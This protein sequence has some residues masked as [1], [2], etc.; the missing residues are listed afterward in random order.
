MK[1]NT[2]RAAALAGLM[3]LGA[4]VQAQAAL[5][6]WHLQDVTFTDGAT[7]SG[8]FTIDTEERYWTAY[9]IST[10][11]GALAPYTYEAANSHFSY[12]GYGSHSF[13]V[14]ENSQQRYINFS[15]FEPPSEARG[16]LALNPAYSWECYN[17]S[18]WRYM[19]GWIVR[20]EAAE[21]PEPATL[22][23]LLPA[24]GMLAWTA[25]RR[26]QQAR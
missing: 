3:F 12:A 5:I 21:V 13:L 20:E 8:W 11:G 18:P 26:K 24:L 19:S 16:P 15:F 9:R 1:K 22:A 14:I 17:C 25:R 7:A 4:A 2:L 6:T 23:L 10:T